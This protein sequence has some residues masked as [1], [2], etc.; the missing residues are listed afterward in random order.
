[1]AST[2]L[3]R[4]TGFQPPS[5]L[6]KFHLCKSQSRWQFKLH[7]FSHACR[8][9]SLRASPC[10]QEME[11][12]PHTRRTGRVSNVEKTAAEFQGRVAFPI[13]IFEFVGGNAPAP[14]PAPQ[15]PV[16]LS[17]HPTISDNRRRVF[18][19]HHRSD[20]RKA[21]NQRHGDPPILKPVT[22]RP[23]LNHTSIQLHPAMTSKRERGGA[24]LRGLAALGLFRASRSLFTKPFHFADKEK[25]TKH[26]L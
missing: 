15:V 17:R 13:S 1:M 6:F 10:T 16:A 20:W 7:N 12:Q 9:S 21:A 24:S 14:A 2:Y 19:T 5:Q 18:R 3:G 8:S 4:G 11:A 25:V 22:S 23:N 26:A